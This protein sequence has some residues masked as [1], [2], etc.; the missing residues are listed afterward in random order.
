[1]S[2]V[3]PFNPK[4]IILAKGTIKNF[5]D[6]K[7][8]QDW[9]DPERFQR[10]KKKALRYIPVRAKDF[11]DNWEKLVWEVRRVFHDDLLNDPDI[12]AAAQKA[13]FGNSAE[14]AATENKDERGPA[15]GVVDHDNVIEVLEWQ[16]KEEETTP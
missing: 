10:Q 2:N 7:H 5:L 11:S 14:P 3:I 8:R 12:K 4:R 1:M 13:C 6:E 15:R 16:R 9:E